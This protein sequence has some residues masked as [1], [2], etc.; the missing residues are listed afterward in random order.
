[1]LDI[2]YIRENVD[3]VK[4]GMINKGEKESEIVDHVL[5]KDEEWRSFVHKLDT[6]RSEN[7]AKAKQIGM[8][9]GQGKKEEAQAIIKETSQF[10]EELKSL[11][12]K[13]KV[14]LSERDDLLYR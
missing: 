1:M 5:L 11:E 13:E 10:K 9:M 8:L 6:L 12:E 2:N 7:N 14:L 3:V 4:Q